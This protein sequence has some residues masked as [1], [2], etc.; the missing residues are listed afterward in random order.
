MNTGTPDLEGDELAIYESVVRNNGAT[1]DEIIGDTGL[2]ASL[3]NSLITVMEI[4]GLVESYAGRIY[5]SR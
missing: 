2:S 4:K 3:V 1:C 5:L